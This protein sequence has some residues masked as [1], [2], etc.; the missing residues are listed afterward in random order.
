MRDQ[1]GHGFTLGLLMGALALL[2]GCASR[3]APEPAPTNRPEQLLAITQGHELIRFKAGQPQQVV[4]KQALQGLAAGERVVGMDFRVARGVLYVLTDRGQLYTADTATGA[5]TPV[6]VGA[7]NNQGPALKGQAVG[8]DFNPVADRIRVVTA[9]G[10]NWRLHPDTGA[11]VDADAAQEGVQGDGALT[12][13]ADDVQAAS[14]P[15]IGAAAYTYNKDNDKL[16]TNYAI[17]LAGARLVM[18]GSREGAT[19]AVSPNTGKL[20]TVGALGVSRVTE[21]AF[22][23]AD[24]NNA[25]LAALGN[26]RRT[27]LYQVD[28]RTGSATLLGTVGDGTPLLGM[29]VEP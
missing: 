20:R 13:A 6:G 1:Q 15:K 2:G 22:D 14:T 26:G 17:D 4:S 12:Y 27:R 21:V 8:V 10:Q 25:A 23:I 19:P 24:T 5:L 9:S 18:Q 7:G 29:A 11:W 16:T 28:L 3:W